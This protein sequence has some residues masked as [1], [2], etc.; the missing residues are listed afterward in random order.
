MMIAPMT[1][2]VDEG[3]TPTAEHPACPGEQ[4]VSHAS[5]LRQVAEVHEY[6]IHYLEARKD[7]AQLTARRLIVI[8]G[9]VGALA[10][11]WM[12]MIL[13]AIMLLLTGVSEG[14]GIILGG[15]RWLGETLVGGGVLAC[16]LF[17]TCVGILWW[18]HASRLRTIRKYER[19]QKIK[20]SKFGSTTVQRN[21]S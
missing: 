16:L 6:L 13:F 7:K 5:L 11:A 2:R 8:T 15:R 19:R 18:N 4:S 9:I 3:R 20:R 17:V 21:A 14:V 12:A 1:D 10:V